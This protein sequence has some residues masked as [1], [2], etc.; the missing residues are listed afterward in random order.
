MYCS[1]PCFA[2]LLPWP[3]LP[4]STRLRRSPLS[5]AQRARASTTL[6]SPAS[7]AQ[8]ARAS[9]ALLSINLC[10]SVW[11]LSALRPQAPRPF[12]RYWRCSQVSLVHADCPLSG[13]GKLSA[14]SAW[15]AWF[16][17]PWCTSPSIY[18]VYIEID[19]ILLQK[20]AMSHLHMK[21]S[22]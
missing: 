19:V 2:L 8:R 11:R 5:R 20:I 1:M 9:V 6:L 10:C 14:I 12:V 4:V 15:W 17:H 7:A 16:L 21:T 18:H 22:F 13:I 3:L